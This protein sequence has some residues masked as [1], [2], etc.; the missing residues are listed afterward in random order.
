MPPGGQACLWRDAAPRSR[1]RPASDGQ[2]AQHGRG[3]EFRLGGFNKQE[4]P[5]LA[6]RAPGGLQ[7]RAGT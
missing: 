2:L 6:D 3:F 1:R 4:A 7:L 5:R